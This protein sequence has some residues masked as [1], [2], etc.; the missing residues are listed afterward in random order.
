MVLH[1]QHP[2]GNLVCLGVG[3]PDN[4]AEVD[5]D[6]H[7]RLGN[8]LYLVTTGTNVCPAGN[9]IQAYVTR[10]R[11]DAHSR[12][13]DWAY[14]YGLFTDT[15]SSVRVTIRNNSLHNKAFKRK[16]WA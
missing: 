16:T 15:D 10:K 4:P 14:A 13:P 2:S 8:S 3:S 12:Q 9:L 6:S 11:G 1:R 5:K 7:F